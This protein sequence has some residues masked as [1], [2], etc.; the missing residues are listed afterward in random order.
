MAMTDWDACRQRLESGLDALGMSVPVAARERLIA[1]LRELTTWNATHNLTA[2][3]DP[4]AMVTR[5]LLD[6]LAV[7][8]FVAGACLVDVGAGPGLPGIV[9]A[10]VRPKLAVT[11]VECN[12]KKAAFL[13][14]ARRQL[15]ADNI[16]VVQSRVENYQPA[17]RFDCLITRAFAAASDTVR[18]AG[19]LIAPGGRVVLMKGRDPA[20]EMAD[21]P[22]DFR[23]VETIPVTV[24]GL[25]AARHVT[26]L[27]PG[28]I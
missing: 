10:I 5:H 28:L 27:E 18:G 22:L 16:D 9:L 8:G 19:H 14:H 6:C 26:I 7:S 1:Y 2:V 15:G 3:R 21:L 11:L 25:G 24:P 4:E 13:R 20:P 12:R 23:H 17:M